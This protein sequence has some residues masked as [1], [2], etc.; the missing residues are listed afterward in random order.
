MKKLLILALLFAWLPALSAQEHAIVLEN[1]E[2]FRML[3]QLKGK[4]TVKRVVAVLDEDGCDEAEF[5]VNTSPFEKVTAFKGTIVYENGKT[6]TLSK[7]DLITV[8]TAT[9]LADDNTITG[10]IPPDNG[11]YTV[12]YDYTVEFSRGIAVFPT[13]APIQCDGTRL[14]KGSYELILPEN[15]QIIFHGINMPE[16]EKS[17]TQYRWSISDVKAVVDE[18]LMPDP[19]TMLPLLLSAPVNFTF[20]K[21]SGS[22][23]CWENL[24]NWDSL[25]MWDCDDLPAATRSKIHKMTDGCSGEL[26]KIRVLYDYLREKTRYVSIQFGIGGFR[27][28]KA[29][30]VDRTGFGDCKALTNY[31]ACLLREVGIESYYTILNTDRKKLFADY[32]CF[33]QTNHVMLTVPLKETADTLYVECTNP[34]VPLGYRHEDVAG[35]DVLILKDYVG[36]F[37]HVPDYPDS[38][39]IVENLWNVSLKADGAA[40]VKVS[41]RFTLDNAEHLFNFRN[42]SEEERNEAIAG[43]FDIHS[44]DLTVTDIRDNFK[45]YDGPSWIPEITIDYTFA[46][47]TYARSGGN[48]IFVPVNNLAK[49]LYY[50]RK[51]RVNPI[52]R[53]SVQNAHDRIVIQLPD[54]FNVESLPDDVVMDE[55]WGLFSSTC[56][57]EGNTVVIDQRTLLRKCHT[58]ADRYPDYKAF[59]R[60]LNKAYANTVVLKHE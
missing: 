55:P 27:P 3:S 58:E 22:Q 36:I 34:S 5:R 25:L 39:G 45:S 59:A 26:E 49:R 10:Y 53:R 31:F 18:H 13:F 15:T 50:Q 38:L 42:W 33:G 48:R 6:E 37:S 11:H 47:H 23:D 44:Q 8:A 2:S 7:S 51:A 40:D 52:E 32:S 17:A 4:H 56:R 21:V 14:V 29:S 35:H 30:V 41:S 46:A 20:D 43:S 16:P 19:I 12:T 28:F 24:G 1:T 60:A 9:E 54:G 57:T